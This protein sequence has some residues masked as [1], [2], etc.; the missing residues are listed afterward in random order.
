M[1]VSF[2]LSF[3]AIIFI[4]V[5]L[6][7]RG[8]SSPNRFRPRSARKRLADEVAA[9]VRLSIATWA[10]LF[11]IIA[12]VFNQINLVG[13]PINIVVIPLMSLVLACGLLLP[14]LGWIPGCGS[15]LSLPAALLER[16]ALWADSLPYSSFPSHA[17]DKMAMLAFYLAVAL[18]S[19]RNMI[20]AGKWRKRWRNGSA[21][22]MFLSFIGLFAGMQ[23][24]PP[25]AGG[26]IAVLP[27]WGFG[28]LVVETETGGL[29][30]LGTVAR[31]G[32]DEAGWLHSQRRSGAVGVI[33]IGRP[34]EGKLY[35]LDY[36]SGIAAAIDLA[37]TDKEFAGRRTGWLPVPGTPGA[38]Y[39]FRR[40]LR[41]RLLWLAA[42][43]GKRSVCVAP[44]LTANQLEMFRNDAA[45]LDF[46]LIFLG[47]LRRDDPDS[48]AIASGFTV[49]VIFFGK[50]DRISRPGWFSRR[51]YGCI[52][53]A[54]DLSGFDG[55]E[56]RRLADDSF[57]PTAPPDPASP[58]GLP[59]GD[60]NPPPPD[61]ASSSPPEDWPDSFRPQ[62]R[63]NGIPAPPPR[64]A[65]DPDR[66]ETAGGALRPN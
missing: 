63:R 51:E 9:L 7:T 37:N 62:E 25:P 55:R 66:P 3:T 27:G 53:L 2:Q 14:C 43:T 54:R 60:K 50:P 33:A 44:F 30:A 34:R 6:E 16:I 61:Q 28:S 56:W 24:A 59:A 10:G 19:I 11:P 29:A 4:H 41:G 15:V 20:H 58:D 5:G 17:P 8:A 46:R 36:H 65:P 31:G 12:L 57:R 49:P 23:S 13:L 35:A 38:E 42:R 18:F 22:S 48:P 47:G 45:R 1:D 26:R 21:V 64:P 40:D 39:A 52:R 32:Q